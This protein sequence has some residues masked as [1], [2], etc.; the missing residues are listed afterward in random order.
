MD[1]FKQITLETKKEY[2]VP[3][4]MIGNKRKSLYII[5]INVLTPRPPVLTNMS[6]AT[7]REAGRESFSSL[8]LPPEES[9]REN[10][11]MYGTIVYA[12]II[13]RKFEWK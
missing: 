2:N 9:Q 8:F 11:R 13:C 5:A 10:E 6:E 3:K 12:S 4:E 7:R 1:S